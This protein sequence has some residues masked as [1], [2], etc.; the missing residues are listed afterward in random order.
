MSGMTSQGKNI[1]RFEGNA[2]IVDGVDIELKYSFVRIRF[3]DGRSAEMPYD[4][5][6]KLITV[7]GVP[8]IDWYARK[9]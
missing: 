4:Q 2:R 1:V 6:N 8:V 3:I 5:A 9:N 7:N